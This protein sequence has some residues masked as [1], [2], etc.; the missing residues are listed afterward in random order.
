MGLEASTIAAWAA[1]TAAATGVYSAANVPK[2]PGAPQEAK[3][4][5]AGMSDEDRRNKLLA[6]LAAGAAKNN[7]SGGTAG[8]PNTGSL[9]LG[10]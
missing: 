4:P 1:A 6:Q 7:P 8:N 2:A 9:T 3:K 10:G 5:D